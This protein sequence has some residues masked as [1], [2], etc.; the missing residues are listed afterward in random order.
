MRG[1][2]LA[3]PF[4][5]APTESEP[6]D[7]LPAG[8]DW[9]YEPKWDGFRCLAFKDGDEVDLRSRNAK[10]LARFFPAVEAAVAA[11][12][13]ARLVLDGE[14]IIA[15]QPFDT[16]QLRL[17]PAASRIELLAKQHAATFVAFDLLADASGASLLARPFAERRKALVA[18]FSASA[19]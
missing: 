5:L 18:L 2:S 1:M 11:L 14:L 12:P 10:P 13:V 17:H 19:S 4:T 7:A 6:V 8:K 15:K 9:Q 16:L 3:V